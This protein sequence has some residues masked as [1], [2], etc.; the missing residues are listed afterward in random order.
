MNDL[1]QELRDAIIDGDVGWS[2]AQ[3]RTGLSEEQMADEF[4]T[5]CFNHF[6]EPVIKRII[7]STKASNTLIADSGETNLDAGILYLLL[8][9]SRNIM[10]KEA[11][12]WEK[13]DV[14]RDSFSQVVLL[15]ET[16]HVKEKR[17]GIVELYES[18]EDI[19]EGRTAFDYVQQLY[20]HYEK[21][22][23]ELASLGVQLSP[24]KHQTIILFG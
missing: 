14:S 12:S 9:E 7:R 24:I 2:T 10:V 20:L 15:L 17:R 18:K 3:E 23:A 6:S 1:K 4:A 16:P 19:K 22:G 8:R 13:I 5:L 21:N 11:N